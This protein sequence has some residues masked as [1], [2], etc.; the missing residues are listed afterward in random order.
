MKSVLWNGEPDYRR[1]G[2]LGNNATQELDSLKVLSTTPGLK[3]TLDRIQSGKGKISTGSL[4][5]GKLHEVD[6]IKMQ[7]YSTI[8]ETEDKSGI[9]KNVSE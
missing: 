2:I 7:R 3:D 1:S 6:I 8:C 5:R 4:K 9:N